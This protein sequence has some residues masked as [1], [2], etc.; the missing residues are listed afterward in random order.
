MQNSGISIII[1]KL[2]KIKSAFKEK[3]QKSSAA[4]LELQKVET[5]KQRQLVGNII[6]AVL[7]ERIPVRKA[8]LLF[9]K[10]F[11][12]PSIHAAWHALCHYEADED[13]KVQDIEFNNQQVE[14][15]ELIAFTF[16]DGNPLAQNIIDAY[17]PYYQDD[18]VSYEN[19][20]KG[21]IKKL[22]RFLNF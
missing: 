11:T 19:G 18:P 15:L 12:D 8:L 10:G 16:K 21:I 9:P 17:K 20:I 2:E 7:T 6:I 5:E 1:K 4:S 13:I 22:F 14:L 3:I